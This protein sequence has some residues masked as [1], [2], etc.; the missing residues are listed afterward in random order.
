MTDLIRFLLLLTVAILVLISKNNEVLVDF[1]SFIYVL[2]IDLDCVESRNVIVAA[3]DRSERTSNDVDYARI[4]SFRKSRLCDCMQ[5]IS[6]EK[7]KP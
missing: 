1:L 7:V 3:A 4:C 6:F 2:L 5:T